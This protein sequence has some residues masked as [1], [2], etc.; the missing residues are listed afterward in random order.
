LFIRVLLLFKSFVIAY[1]NFVW[2]FI[3]QSTNLS[4]N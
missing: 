3:Y 4:I 1:K 2:V